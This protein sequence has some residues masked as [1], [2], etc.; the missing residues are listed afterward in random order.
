M[1]APTVRLAGLTWS[2]SIRAAV[3]VTDIKT[4][5]VFVTPIS[6]HL[7]ESQFGTLKHLKWFIDRC[8]IFTDTITL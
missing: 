6:L 4:R 1:A 3:R 8:E 5:K 7:W 2:H